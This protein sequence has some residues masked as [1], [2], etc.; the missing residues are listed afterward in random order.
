MTSLDIRAARSASSAPY[1]PRVPALF[2]PGARPSTAQKGARGCFPSLLVVSCGV[3][4]VLYLMSKCNGAD[5]ARYGM[6]CLADLRGASPL[7][8]S[9]GSFCFHLKTGRVGWKRSDKN[10]HVCWAGLGMFSRYTSTPLH[11][12]VG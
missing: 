7:S 11:L 4:E 10:W 8:F 5:S 2:S 3:H 9:D 6:V 1:A 12:A